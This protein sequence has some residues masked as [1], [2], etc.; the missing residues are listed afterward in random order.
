MKEMKKSRV[1]ICA[2]LLLA[3]L[4][5]A[6]MAHAEGKSKLINLEIVNEVN[7]SAA[8]WSGSEGNRAT[9][10]FAALV[11]L[12]KEDSELLTETMSYALNNDVCYYTVKDETIGFVA[13]GDKAFVM[14][15]YGT[16]NKIAAYAL[17]EES[18]AFEYAEIIMESIKKQGIIDEYYKVDSSLVLEMLNQLLEK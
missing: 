3:L 4:L 9:F 6:V 18:D 17:S 11:D 2:A 12:L 5:P 1:F 13:F 16:E 8:Q 10:V 14:L 15:S 7:G